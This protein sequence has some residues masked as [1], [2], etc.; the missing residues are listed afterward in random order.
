MVDTSPVVLESVVVKGLPVALESL[1]GAA[2]GDGAGAGDAAT[3]GVDEVG[4]GS[5]EP[6]QNGRPFSPQMKS[7]HIS[8]L[9][10]KQ[11]VMVKHFGVTQ[12]QALR[13]QA[14]LRLGVTDEDVRI[15]ERLMGSRSEGADNTPSKEEWLLGVTYAQ[16]SFHKALQV[17]GISEA[18][19][20]EERSRRLGELGSGGSGGRASECGA[21]QEAEDTCGRFFIKKRRSSTEE[22]GTTLPGEV[23]FANSRVLQLE[24]VC[25][26]Q[27]TRIQELESQLALLSARSSTSES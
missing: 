1:K 18:V 2:V 22:L 6:E 17:L 8:T 24:E 5:E 26:T 23:A 25:H 12:K 7:P 21:G 27:M 10:E 20:E 14:L 3:P 16:M 9:Y 13:T 4:P 11:D 19:V 15:A